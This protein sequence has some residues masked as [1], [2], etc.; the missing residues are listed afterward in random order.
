MTNVSSQGNFYI[1][2]RILTNAMEDPSFGFKGINIANVILEYFY[3]GLVMMCF[4]LALGNRPQGSKWA[5]TLA[6]VGFA[7]LTIYMTVRTPVELLQTPIFDI[8]SFSSLPY[9]SRTRASMAF[10]RKK[11]ASLSPMSSR[12]RSSEISCSR[13]LR[14]RA[15]T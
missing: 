5:F 12:I 3:I 13:S 2:F 7:I 11:A 10:Q 9:S 4:I 14:Q 1:A 6:F 15:Y 8:P